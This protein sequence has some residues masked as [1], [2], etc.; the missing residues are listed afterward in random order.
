MEA[1][2]FDLGLE[3]GAAA[4]LGAIRSFNC[5]EI[6]LGLS[7]EVEKFSGLDIS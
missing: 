6:D 1:C 4:V 3:H 5:T 7:G 2:H